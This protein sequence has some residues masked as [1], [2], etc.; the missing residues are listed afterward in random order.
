MG[1]LDGNVLVHG[2]RGKVGD[3]LVFRIV[4]RKTVV[5]KAPST[6]N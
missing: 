2:L 4:D 6:A 3:L 1:K 5:A